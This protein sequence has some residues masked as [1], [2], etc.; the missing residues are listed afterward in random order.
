MHRIDQMGGG[1]SADTD[2]LKDGV[3][4]GMPGDG[5]LRVYAASSVDTATI[6][7]TPAVHQ[8]PSGAVAQMIVKATNAEV[9]DYN[10][11]F[12]TEVSLGEKVVI[13]VAGT[14]GTYRWWVQFFGG[15]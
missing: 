8:N 4:D 9:R 3:L 11:Y 2:V 6:S 12:E 10:P 15:Q 5:L 14:T 1:T 13:A 7:V